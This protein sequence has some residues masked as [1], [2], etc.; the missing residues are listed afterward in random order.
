MVLQKL[1]ELQGIIRKRKTL[2]RMRVPEMVNN[3]FNSGLRA[4]LR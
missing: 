3:G 2:A 4:R 1:F